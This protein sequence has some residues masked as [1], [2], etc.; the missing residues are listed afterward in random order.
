MDSVH[1]PDTGSS[2]ELLEFPD[3]STHL[4]IAK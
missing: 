4:L 3:S 1:P 2:A